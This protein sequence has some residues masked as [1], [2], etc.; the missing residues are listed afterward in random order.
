METIS[1]QP[2]T[3]RYFPVNAHLRSV[4]VYIGLGRVCSLDRLA[5]RWRCT[6]ARRRTHA[7]AFMFVDACWQ[8][9]FVQRAMRRSLRIV[10]ARPCINLCGLRGAR[11]AAGGNQRNGKHK[12]VPSEVWPV[13]CRPL[14]SHLLLSAFPWPL[15]L[16]RLLKQSRAQAERSVIRFVSLSHWCAARA[17]NQGPLFFGCTWQAQRQLSAK[18]GRAYHGGTR[19]CGLGWCFWPGAF[20]GH[21]RQESR[22]RRAEVDIN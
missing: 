15:V 21:C 18:D 17:C 16:M 8:V 14:S 12:H 2:R 13:S 9:R 3:S 5:E 20:R 11:C 4:V 1:L 22:C 19:V 7:V 6:P 10:K